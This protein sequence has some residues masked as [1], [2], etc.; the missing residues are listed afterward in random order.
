MLYVI[1][2][3]HKNL[4]TEGHKRNLTLMRIPQCDAT[5]E[6]CHA[7]HDRDKLVGFVYIGGSRATYPA[8][9]SPTGTN[10]FIFAY[11]FTEK[12]PR[13]WST[14][15]TS[16]RPS[17]GNPGSATGLHQKCHVHN[18]PIPAPRIQLALLK[19]SLW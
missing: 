8:H 10:S 19:V 16:Q 17:T 15:P 11:I 5:G 9:A 12:P 2:N 18:M 3:F 4:T 1:T 14:P 7:G 13:R 6:P